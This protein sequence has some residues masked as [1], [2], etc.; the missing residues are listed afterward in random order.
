MGLMA[1]LDGD[2]PARV[3]LIFLKSNVEIAW[4]CNCFSACSMAAVTKEKYSRAF[5]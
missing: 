4:I 1:F 2:Y 5:S 3:F